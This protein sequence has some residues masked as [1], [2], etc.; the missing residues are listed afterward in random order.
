MG[1]RGY[2][3]YNIFGGM[4]MIVGHG[5]DAQILVRLVPLLNDAPDLLMLF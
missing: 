5:I 4:Y 2:N 1:Y 3:E